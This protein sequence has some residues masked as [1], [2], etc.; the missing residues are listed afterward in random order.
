MS[1]PLV[2]RAEEIEYED[3]DAADGMAKG[4]LVGGPRRSNLAIR[5]FTLEPGGSVPR[6]TNE[7]E[8]E[9]HVLSGPTPSASKERSTKLRPATASTSPPARSTGTATTATR[10]APSS[11]R[12]RPGTTPSNWWRSRPQIDQESIGPNA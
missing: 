10:K 7:I 9:Q 3:V 8:H 12:C 5:R 2:R 1:D 11:V 4:V 6:H